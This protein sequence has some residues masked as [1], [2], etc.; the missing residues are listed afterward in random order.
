M[1]KIMVL[2]NRRCFL[3]FVERKK[4]QGM[5][6]LQ[7]VIYPYYIFLCQVVRSANL[8]IYMSV[9]SIWYN[10]STSSTKASLSNSK[11]LKEKKKEKNAW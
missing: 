1:N 7:S 6:I 2:I 8:S 4:K 9:S 10:V 11:F 3:W 5:V